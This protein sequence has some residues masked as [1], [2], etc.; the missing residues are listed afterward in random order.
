MSDSNRDINAEL[1]EA[2]KKGE[3]DKVKSLISE[4]ADVDA[5]DNSKNTALHLAAQEGYKEVIEALL[6]KG[7][8]VNAKDKDG[9]TPRNL[10]TNEAI[11]TLLQNTAK[12][13]EAAKNSDIDEVRRLI[14]EGASVN[15]TDQDGKTPLHWAARN[16]KKEVVEALLKVNGINVN[17]YDKDNNTPLHLAVPNGYEGVVEILLNKGADLD[18]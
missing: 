18:V 3:F 8:N 14:S 13:L 7:A 15:A 1:L 10:T 5:T 11:Q 2:V 6:D 16:G 17:A 12:L 4:G 9:K